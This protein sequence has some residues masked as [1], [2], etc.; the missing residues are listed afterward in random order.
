MRN[1]HLGE[2]R[3]CSSSNFVARETCC[4]KAVLED[5]TVFTFFHVFS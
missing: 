2:F 5:E 1:H 4:L 3:H